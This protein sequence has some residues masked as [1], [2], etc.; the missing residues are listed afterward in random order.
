MYKYTY[1]SGT[2]CLKFG[3]MWL[4]QLNSWLTSGGSIGLDWFSKRQLLSA[5]LE[6]NCTFTEWVV[7]THYDQKVCVSTMHAAAVVRLTIVQANLTPLEVLV[8]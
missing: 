4:A 1:I 6:R 3:Y 2:A 7:S 5:P 8:S